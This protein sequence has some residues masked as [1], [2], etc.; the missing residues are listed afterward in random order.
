[1]PKTTMPKS[2]SKKQK[3]SVLKVKSC[4]ESLREKKK[5]ESICCHDAVSNVL[6][7]QS[8]DLQV[9]EWNIK[10]KFCYDVSQLEGMFL[11]KSSWKGVQGV[12]AYGSYNP[13]QIIDFVMKL[14]HRQMNNV[15]QGRKLEKEIDQIFEVAETDDERCEYDFM[16][17][18]EEQG[19]QVLMDGV[20][21]IIYFGF[22]IND[23]KSIIGIKLCVAVTDKERK[24]N[25][26][27]FSHSFYFEKATTK[28]SKDSM[29]EA[30]NEAEKKEKRLDIPVLLSSRDGLLNTAYEIAQKVKPRAILVVTSTNERVLDMFCDGR[31]N[32]RSSRV[33]ALL[34]FS[35]S[36]EA[37]VESKHFSDREKTLEKNLGRRIDPT[38]K[39]TTSDIIAYDYFAQQFPYGFPQQWIEKH[40]SNGLLSVNN[41]DTIIFCTTCDYFQDYILPSVHRECNPLKQ[42]FGAVLVDKDPIVE[43]FPM[44]RRRKRKKTDYHEFLSTVVKQ[45]Q[46]RNNRAKVFK[47]TFHQQTKRS[48]KYFLK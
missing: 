27:I 29:K 18:N 42:K 37:F 17:L 24:I 23:S 41:D 26:G 19:K 36:E 2:Q 7:G 21:P 3:K 22:L 10:G 45:Y 12:T 20:A 44:H 13:A 14:V 11:L 9:C 8:I 1:M 31:I 16:G 38:K 33:R 32:N 28:I 48:Q 34:C 25:G 4:N 40:N 15:G 39:P 35:H 5:T 46:K 30:Y 43:L 47:V 6:N